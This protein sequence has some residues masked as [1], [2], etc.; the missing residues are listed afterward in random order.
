MTVKSRLILEIGISSKTNKKRVFKK[1]QKMDATNLLKKKFVDCHVHCLFSADSQA[2]IEEIC[3]RA[4][5]KGFHGI[6]FTDHVD[7][8]LPKKD[9][10]FEFDVPKRATA[11][12]QAQQAYGEKLRI[13]HGIE[14]GFQPQVLEQNKIW[15]AKYPYDFVIL[16]VHM[17]ERQN[18]A[19]SN[20]TFYTTRTKH[21]A[22]QSYLEQIYASVCACNDYDSI[23]HIGYIQRYGP[24]SDRSLSYADHANILDALLKKV[25]ESNKGIEINTSGLRGNVGHTLPN[26]QILRRYRELGGTLI[27]IGS[28]A[29]MADDVGAHFDEAA[30]LL[31]SLGFTHVTHFEKRRPVCTQL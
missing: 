10:V 13:F 21:E 27:T 19:D 26:E 16:S 29:H 25:I 22:I 1:G 8:D 30:R 28:D 12:E 6:T 7:L 18:L 3:A 9:R 5:A 17:A 11:L 14:I 15:L 2:P 24:W 31:R 20:N 23:G 4:Y